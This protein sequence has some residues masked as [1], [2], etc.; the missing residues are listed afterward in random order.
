MTLDPTIGEIESLLRA[1]QVANAARKLA[2]AAD[3]GNVEAIVAMAHWSIAGNIVPR[4]LARARTCLRR[5]TAAGD[6]AAA[7]L[8]VNFLASETGGSADWLGGLA[9]LET[10]RGRPEADAQR[11]LIEA[12]DLDDQGMPGQ[13]PKAEVFAQRPEITVVRSL[14]SEPECAYLI[15][16]GQ[17]SLAP[18]LVVNPATGQ[19]VPHPVRVCDN[20]TFGVFL[21]DAVV[22]AI[23]RRI[24]AATGTAYR[25]GEALQLLRY[26]KGGEYRAHSDAITGEANQRI[27]TV[28][29]YLNDGYEGGQTCF[30]RIGRSFKGAVGDALIFRNSLSG[31]QA[32]PLALHAGAPVTDGVKW[33][34]SRWIRETPFNFPA[35]RPML[36]SWR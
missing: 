10:L 26:T 11:Q 5:A 6:E 17:A 36:P 32:D 23:N 9:V 35:P 27:M 4:D 3:R 12:M 20:A 8:L 16:K 22:S 15:A 13:L 24:A 31:G 21:E 25:Q 33:L 1:G 29:I 18:A 30:S 19:M 14:I 34:S 28:L 2:D 7:L